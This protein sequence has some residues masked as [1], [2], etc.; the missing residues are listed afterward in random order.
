MIVRP[1]LDPKII[2]K[3][4]WKRMLTLLIISGL[5][6][7]ANLI[8]GYTHIK[9][10][11]LPATVLGTA[12]A[13]LTSFRVNSAYDRWWEARRLW[14]AIINDSRTIT[15]QM[16]TFLSYQDV[17]KVENRTEHDAYVRELVYRQIAFAYSLKNHLR[18][19]DI[20]EEI[21]DF[22]SVEELEFLKKQQHIP[23]AI[24]QRQ[25]ETLHDIHEK[26]YMDSFQHVQIE[27]KLSTLCDAMGGCERI[28]NTVFPRQ[29]SIYSSTFIRIY[30]YFLPFVMVN[31]SGWVTIPA[32]L[33]IGF[34]FFAMDTIA[35]GIEN[36]FENGINDTPM[37]AL[38]RTIEINLRQQL[39]ETDLPK[40]I[41]PVRGFL[42]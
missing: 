7:K 14:G 37:S 24:L 3:I 31:G 11:T 38:C 25:A 18:K 41:Q 29:Y 42:Y 9:I 26:G 4:A 22:V 15:R 23:N 33:L 28:K 8:W 34:I 6:V 40:P 17:Q 36:P 39:G 35:K 20:F 5:V 30:T 1:N 10:D 21:K 19:Q 27:T 32:T 13:I 2:I 12:L 16:T